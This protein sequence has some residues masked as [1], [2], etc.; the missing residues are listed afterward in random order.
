MEKIMSKSNDTERTRELTA[1]L[2]AV[3][4]GFESQEHTTITQAA[5]ARPTGNLKWGDIVLKRP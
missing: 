3:S 2:D 5:L 4:G 1:D